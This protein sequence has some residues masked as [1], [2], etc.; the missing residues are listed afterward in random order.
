MK[1]EDI[2]IKWQKKW[3]K[4]GLFESE[5]SKKNKYFMVFAY[6]TISGTLHVGHAR[7]YVIP[8]VIARYKRMRDFNVFF[9]LGFHATGVHTQTILTEVSKD[10]KNATKYGIYPKAAAKFKTPLDVDKYLEMN[11]IKAFKR[12]GLSLDFRPVVST[13][14]PQYNKFIQWQFKKLRNAGYIIQ[15]DYRVAWCPDCNSP[16]SLDSAEMDIKEWKGAQIKDYVVIKF[17]LGDAI[18]P[19]STLR[20]ETIFGVTNVWINPN[21]RY[22]RAKVDDEK[23]IISEKA[24]KKLKNFGK[25]VK[26]EEEIAGQELLN[27][28]VINPANKKEVPVLPGEFVDA[29]E[30]TGVVMSVPS[31]DPFDYIYLKKVAPEIKPIQVV[32]TKGFGPIPAEELLEKYN[33][34]YESDPK[35]EEITNELYK[36]EY[37]G[38]MLSSIPKFGGMEVS[39]AKKE[40]EKWLRETGNADMV[41]ELSAKPIYCRCGSEIVVKVVK[42]QWFIDYSNSKWKESSKHCV[43]KMNI[44]PPQYKKELPGIIDWLIER[45]CVRKRG[46]GTKFPF[47]D[48]WIIEA[49]SDSTI[50][51]SFYTVSKYF[52]EKKIG[53]EDLTDEFFDY[54]FLGIGKPKS[55]W[56]KI[57][58]E[59]LYWYP[60]DLNSGGKEHKSAHFPLFVMNHVAVFPEDLW[61]KGIFVN[62]H[63]IAYGKKLS[64]HLGNVVFWDDAIKIYGADTL[65]LYMSHGA[66]QWEDFDWK[67]EECEIYKK[68]LETIDKVVK[69]IMKNEPKKSKE[70]ID[71]WFESRINRIIEE[72]TAAMDKNEIKRAANLIF[73]SILTDLYWYKKREKINPEILPVWLKLLS[74]FVPHYCEE[75]WNKLGNKT[76]ITIEKWPSYDSEKIRLKEEAAEEEVR[77]ILRDVEEIKKLSKI[78]RPKKITLFV[79]PDWKHEVFNAV[80][81]GIELREVI[82]KYKGK[83]KEVSNYYVKLQKRKP[84]EEKFL[85][86]HEM[87]H[88][89]ETKDF[90]EKELDCEIE[91][92]SAEKSNHPKSLVAEP[93]KPGILIE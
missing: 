57:R 64:K 68:H 52:N 56:K 58:E 75:I 24:A 60:L 48:G 28:K 59:F 90:L 92:M 33:V 67:N 70:H 78:M 34:K 22:V 12:I 16:V 7:S 20:P 54:V 89:E 32:E 9:P 73:F 3:E 46:L 82:K 41:F 30:A 10:L 4:E 88:L 83:E 50:Y 1:T 91:I 53:L 11:M 87:N 26:I 51:M 21:E 5:P 49:L 6:P 76:S 45:P 47:E 62:W 61:P 85:K 77:T 17:R 79:A 2:E 19:A 43:E 86:A 72:A 36:I 39:K 23:W 65:R 74:P 63:L 13:I 29:D 40:V 14:D 42:G 84:L 8:D 35:I 37:G 69:E 25:N 38:S 80:L 27:T 81:E 66:N 44:Y 93:E 31:H 71:K 18:L 15:K 55:D